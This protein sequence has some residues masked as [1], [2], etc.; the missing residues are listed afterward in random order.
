MG[1]EDIDEEK[2]SNKQS[3]NLYFCEKKDIPIDGTNDIRLAPDGFGS[4]K[5]LATDGLENKIFDT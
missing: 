3:Y 5:Q 4:I 2:S 1:L